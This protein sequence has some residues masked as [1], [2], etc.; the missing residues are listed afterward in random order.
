MEPMDKGSHP[1]SAPPALAGPT[2]I[3]IVEE[4]LQVGTQMVD[5]DTVRI[6]ITPA[7]TGVRESVSLKSE[8]IVIERRPGNGQSITVTEQAFKPQDIELTE[9]T[10][11]PV[12]S[13][14]P[15]V[16]NLVTIRKDAVQRTQRVQDRVRGTT[17]EVVREPQSLPEDTGTM[18]LN[19]ANDTAPEKASD[20]WKPLSLPASFQEVKQRLTIGKREVPEAVVRV[21]IR[22]TERPVE[23]SVSLRQE[24]VII[25]RMPVNDA[26]SQITTP[27]LF[28]NKNIEI[29]TRKEVPIITKRP[30]VKEL[31][32]IRKD[33]STRDKTIEAKLQETTVALTDPQPE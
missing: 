32:T 13:I 25:E 24:Q 1:G 29:R 5:S 14:R 18:Q 3:P 27:D 26:N 19:T 9:M 2:T 7:E 22:P 17:V 21:R 10:E 12:A 20:S 31:L 30:V 23:Q 33:A 11:V 15:V 16:T 28:R 6:K 4:E 8:R